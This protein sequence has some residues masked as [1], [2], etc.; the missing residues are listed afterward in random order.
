MKEMRKI[1]NQ[2]YSLVK[3]NEKLLNTDPIISRI[4]EVKDMHK[5]R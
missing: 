3:G 2:N 4:Y 1:Y 5:K